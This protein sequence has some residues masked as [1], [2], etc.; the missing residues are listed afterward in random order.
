MFMGAAWVH[1]Q[2]VGGPMAGLHS[3]SSPHTVEGGASFIVRY[4]GLAGVQERTQA[5]VLWR[6]EG[7]AEFRCLGTLGCT[8]LA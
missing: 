6:G 4:V 3:P 1:W 7:T 5:K 2:G 8:E